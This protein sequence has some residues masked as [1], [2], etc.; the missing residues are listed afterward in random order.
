MVIL[1]MVVINTEKNG[2]PEG[3]IRH[4]IDRTWWEINLGVKVGEVSKMNIKFWIMQQDDR[5]WISI[6]YFSIFHSLDSHNLDSVNT[7][8]MIIIIRGA[9]LYIIMRT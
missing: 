2:C 4:N 7:L 1:G 8:L 9:Y 3:Y 5:W 6:E